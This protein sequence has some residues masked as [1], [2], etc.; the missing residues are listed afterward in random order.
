MNDL[1]DRIA[2]TLTGQVQNLHPPGDLAVR[3]LRRA[4]T[5]R[6]RQAT[7]LAAVAV[8]VGITVPAV[9]AG[10]RAGSGPDQRPPVATI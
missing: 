3:C 8:A 1:E 2:G 5:V 6:R 10:T 7:V 9:L 4:R